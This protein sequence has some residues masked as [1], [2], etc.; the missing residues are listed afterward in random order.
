MATN[1]GIPVVSGLTP[2]T[3]RDTVDAH[4]AVRINAPDATLADFVEL[5]A[6]LMTPMVHHATNTIERDPVAD[7]PSTSTVNKGMDA[8]PLHREAS[9]APGCPDLLMFYC[10][11]PAAAGGETMLCDGAE[12]L[13]RLDSATRAFVEVVDLY[14]S[15]EATPARWQQTL[16]VR[17]V[18]EAK[19]VL[20]VVGKALKPY[21][22]LEAHF[23]G[24]LLCG[25]FRTKA[26]IPTGTSGSPAFC[27]SLMIYAYRE[28]SE[29]YA[30]DNFQVTLNDGS[31][32]PKDLL[33]E[34]KKIADDVTVDIAW[35]IQG[36]M[37]VVD[38]GRFMHGRRDFSDTNRRILIR[39]GYQKRAA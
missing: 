21:E 32:F 18:P 1:A 29:Y 11:R 17:T 34:I 31:P 35:T 5:S 3:I 38:N 28:K 14:W 25:K 22:A 9:Y 37:V 39:M 24:D 8:I 26:V 23:R 36:E 7:D 13:R 4:G 15:W 20:A 10:D 12:L 27:N 16:G 6:A 19:A 30:K 2:Q 33:A